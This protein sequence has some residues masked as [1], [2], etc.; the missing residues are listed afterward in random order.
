[1]RGQVKI[2]TSRNPFQLRPAK[3]KLVFDV[4]GPAR[5]VRELVL[6]VGS[7]AQ[8]IGL[9]PEPLIPDETLLLPVLEPLH[10][11]G[12]RHEV[13]EFHLLELAQAKDGVAWRDLVAERLADLRDAEGRAH[14]RR[15]EDIGKV[16][17]DPLGCLGSQVDLRARV[18]HRP[19]EGLEHQVELPRFG[20]FAAVLLVARPTHLVGAEALV[21]FPALQQWVGEVLDVTGRH[22]DLGVHENAG[23]DAHDVVAQLDH[24]APPGAFDVV[25]QRHSQ[26]AEV[27]HALDATVDLAR[28]IKEAAAL[29]EGDE[30]LHQRLRLSSGLLRH[31]LRG[32]GGTVGHC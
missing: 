29:R 17:E 4:E 21:T 11:V 7:Q 16:H 2:P 27:V 26:G 20:E 19:G 31:G 10:L 3:R 9:D 18:L 8:V 32:L 14:P 12:G 15:V 23:V 22:P 24:A 1:M 6:A 13:L 5:V 25:A 30:L 28:L